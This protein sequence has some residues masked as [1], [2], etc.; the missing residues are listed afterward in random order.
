MKKD[1]LLTIILTVVVTIFFGWFF[2]TPDKHGNNS[3]E[4][5]TMKDGVITQSNGETV[6]TIHD[7][8]YIHDTIVWAPKGT[9]KYKR[10]DRSY[11][12][13]N[14]DKSPAIMSDKPV[15]IKY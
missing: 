10:M 11:I 13:T 9:T 5:S 3:V 15:T 1:T 12:E 2:F 6:I 8:I 7:T 4:I 14:G